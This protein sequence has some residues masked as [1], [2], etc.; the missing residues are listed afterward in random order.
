MCGDETVSRKPVSYTDTTALSCPTSL[1]RISSTVAVNS[2]CSA[3]SGS[4]PSG[5]VNSSSMSPK[6]ALPSALSNNESMLNF[7]FDPTSST[8]NSTLPLKPA[9]VA[10]AD[11]VQMCAF[12][13]ASA[14]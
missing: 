5:S 4:G 8:R 6:L 10:L 1:L 2:P 11:P 14:T 12:Q 9:N 13:P 7:D 3:S